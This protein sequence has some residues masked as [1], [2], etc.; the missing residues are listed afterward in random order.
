MQST[1]NV[2]LPWVPSVRQLT[3][4]HRVNKLLIS[5]RCYIAAKWCSKI[6]QTLDLGVN[7][8]IRNLRNFNPSFCCLQQFGPRSGLT[9]CHPDLDP[10]CMTLIMF[11]NIFFKVNFEKKPSDNN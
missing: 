5:D 6:A 9:K 10:N 7:L 2:K 11:L 1:L 4:V 8:S 3:P